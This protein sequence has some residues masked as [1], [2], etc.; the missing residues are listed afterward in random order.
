[1]EA[2]RLAALILF[3]SLAGAQFVLAVAMSRTAARG[4]EI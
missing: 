3:E 1:L 4:R 2:E